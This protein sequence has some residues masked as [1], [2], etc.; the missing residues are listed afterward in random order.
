MQNE[1][2]FSS[3]LELMGRFKICVHALKGNRIIFSLDCL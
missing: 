3:V 2:N 1:E